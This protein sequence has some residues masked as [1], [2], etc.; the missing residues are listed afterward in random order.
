MQK[1]VDLARKLAKKLISSLPKEKKT[2]V[3]ASDFLDLLSKLY[4]R[5]KEFR[6]FMLNPLIPVDKKK[7]Y[8]E[9][10]RGKFGLTKDIDK[11]MHL[12]V[13]VGAFPMIEEIKRL[14][15]REMENLLK[16]AKAY[17]FLAKDADMVQVERI[18]NV[19]SKLVGRDL[20]FEVREDPSLIGGFVVKTASFV[21]DTSVKRN[22]EKVL[23]E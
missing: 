14:Y 3:Q 6:D 12:L 11:V 20:E 10:L 1:N 22:L 17:L 16:L 21:L 9:N 7:A 5:E 8:M 23:R 13:E 4:R 2:M 19:L 18:K 15:D